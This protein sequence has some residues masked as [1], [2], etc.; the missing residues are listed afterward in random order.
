MYLKEGTYRTR[1]FR[2]PSTNGMKKWDGPSRSWPTPHTTP[3]LLPHSSH[4]PPLPPPRRPLTG[5]TPPKLDPSRK[6]R[7]PPPKPYLPPQTRTR[8]RRA[9]RPH[10]PMLMRGNTPPTTRSP[11]HRSRLTGDPPNLQPVTVGEEERGGKDPTSRRTPMRTAPDCRP[12]PTARHASQ[13]RSSSTCHPPQQHRDESPQPQPE[14]LLSLQQLPPFYRPPPLY[15]GPV[16]YASIPPVCACPPQ[17]QRRSL[18]VETTP[19]PYALW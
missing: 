2:G 9:H 16:T 3:L 14:L 19:P 7:T 11:P 1:L 15:P 12:S 13:P 6:R 4:H 17:E 8:H 10:V 18:P 5:P